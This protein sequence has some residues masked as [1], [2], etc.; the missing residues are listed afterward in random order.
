M[1]SLGRTASISLQCCGR[2]RL[3]S[4]DVHDD[5]LIS[6][7]DLELLERIPQGFPNARVP[8]LR[9][10]LHPT[11]VS[12]DNKCRSV[13][14]DMTDRIYQDYKDIMSDEL[15]PVPMQ[16]GRKMHINMTENS[17]PFKTLIARRVPLRFEDEANK[18]INDLIKKGV[19][20]P[21]T[22]TTN[23]CSPA[24][25]LAKADGVRVRLVTDYTKLNKYVKRP[26]H[27]FP[28]TRDIIQSVP[29]GQSFRQTRRSSRILSNCLRR[30]KLLLDDILTPTG[31]IQVLTCTHGPECIIKRMVLSLRQDYSWSAMGQKNR[32]RHT[33]LGRR[34]VHTKRHNPHSV[35][36]MQTIQRYNFKKEI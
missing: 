24:F 13:K 26:V 16:T 19:I 27:P 36:Q 33:D 30:R 31:E 6:R 4:E 10:I 22:E 11:R 17:R 3:L 5:C 23:W 25:F 2:H 14:D 29:K 35:R 15:N 20:T 34:H 21:V 28:A 8:R 12:Q 32:R 9:P 1:T 18:T 7:T